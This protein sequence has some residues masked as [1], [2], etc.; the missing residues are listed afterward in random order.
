MTPGGLGW[1]WIRCIRVERNPVLHQE[2]GSER[3]I[4]R[5]QPCGVARDAAWQRHDVGGRGP[6]RDLPQCSQAGEGT[7]G[8]LGW[9]HV[10]TRTQ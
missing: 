8:A 9:D 2:V 6:S 1:G 3:G 10:H 4:P 5:K 7:V